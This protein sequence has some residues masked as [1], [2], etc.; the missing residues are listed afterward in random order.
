MVKVKDQHGLSRRE[1]D[2]L[3][4]IAE[5]CTYAEIAHALGVGFE[6]VKSYL[7][8]IRAKLGMRTRT[9]LAVWWISRE[10]DD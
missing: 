2:I 7:A 6:T 4:K 1:R 3:A 8:R 5:G 9:R 10:E